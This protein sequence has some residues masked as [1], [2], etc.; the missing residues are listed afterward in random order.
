M[1]GQQQETVVGGTLRRLVLALLVA[2]LMAATMAVSAMP[3]MADN[4]G[5]QPS[6]PPLFTGNNDGGTSG[7][8]VSHRFGGTNSVCVAHRNGHGDTGGDCP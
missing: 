6:G 3:A 5:E 2:A 8:T 7:S 1:M 4:S